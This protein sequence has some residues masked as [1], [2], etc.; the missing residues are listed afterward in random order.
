MQNLRRPAGAHAAVLHLLQFSAD[1]TG[2]ALAQRAA[3]TA[4]PAAGPHAGAIGAHPS[5]PEAHRRRMTAPTGPG[6]PPLRMED[7]SCGR[8]GHEP[9][10]TGQ[11]AGMAGRGGARFVEETAERAREVM[12]CTYPSSPF[13]RCPPLSLPNAIVKQGTTLAGFWCESREKRRGRFD[14]CCAAE[15]SRLCVAA[16]SGIHRALVG[17]QVSRVLGNDSGNSTPAWVRT[18]CLSVP[19]TDGSGGAMCGCL[20]SAEA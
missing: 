10:K 17:E 20:L 3:A 16:V 7:R 2:L 19:G 9:Q 13:S 12:P 15:Q 5:T 11:G 18:P 4:L 8:T 1:A 6:K 14:C